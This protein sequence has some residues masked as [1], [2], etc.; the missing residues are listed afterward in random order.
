MEK[1]KF[2]IK[3]KFS[4]D[5]NPIY[6]NGMYGGF[7][8]QGEMVINFYHERWPVP[9]SLIVDEKGNEEKID[10]SDISNTLIRMVKTGV[11]MRKETAI[12]FRDWL[13][14]FIEANKETD[15]EK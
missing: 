12:S 4:D 15:D 14:A 13:N 8:P 5:Y 6:V 3:Y 11:V 9:N 1:E 10:P 7:S 2:T